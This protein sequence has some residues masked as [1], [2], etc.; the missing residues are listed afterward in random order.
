MRRLLITLSLCLFGLNANAQ[1]FSDMTP[2]QRTAFGEAVRSYL[3]ENPEV[4]MEAVAILQE[5]E[6]QAAVNND[7]ELAL[8]YQSQLNDDGY[9]FVGG[10]P[11][12]TINLVEFIDYRCGYCRRAHA[13]VRALVAANDD[14]RYV[15]KEFPILGEDSVVASRAAL[16]VLVN[17]GEEVYYKMNDLL[18]TFEGPYNDAT[19]ED[20]ALEAG[21]DPV[22]MAELMNTPLITD[23]IANNRALA[24]RIQ[25]T[26]TPTF[27]FGNQMVRGY[28]SPDVMNALLEDARDALPQQ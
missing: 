21:A 26:G 7:R 10:N 28:V 22:R 16:A 9:S 14:I 15:I 24:Q 18:M 27:V 3:L 4:V 2:D 23:M 5:R 19:L 12:G 11:D 25:I 1:N 17:D 20:M 6:S 8:R 13:E